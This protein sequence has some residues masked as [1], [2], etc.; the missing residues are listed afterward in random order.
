[1]VGRLEGWSIPSRVNVLQNTADRQIVRA[2][3]LWNIKSSNYMSI[4][5]KPGY[6]PAEGECGGWQPS[7]YMLV[8]Y[9]ANIWQVLPGAT[10][11]IVL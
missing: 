6:T 11:L 10:E 2:V 4:N 9:S 3:F 5:E 7:Y 1:M 8:L